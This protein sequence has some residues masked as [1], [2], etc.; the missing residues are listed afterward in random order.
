MRAETYAGGFEE[1]HKIHFRKML[2]A[3]ELHVLA[4]MRQALLVIIFHDRACLD[5]KP[6]FRAIL[7]LMILADIIFQ[8][9]GKCAGTDSRILRQ[10]I[11]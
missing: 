2:R 11:A 5:G 1:I 6:E 8:S 7:R 4:K 9:V 3:V 10:L